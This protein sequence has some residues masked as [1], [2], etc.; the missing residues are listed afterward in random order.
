MYV[1]VFKSKNSI[2]YQVQRFKYMGAQDLSYDHNAKHLGVTFSHDK[3]NA[4][5][6]LVYDYYNYA[7]LN[8]FL[9]VFMSAPEIKS[10]L[11]FLINYFQDIYY[12]SMRL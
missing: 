2:S 4:I 6:Y 10:I 5:C 3:M 8:R 9:Q 7:K 12:K 11:Y 1:I